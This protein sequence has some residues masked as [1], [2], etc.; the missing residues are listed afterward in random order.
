[1]A[2][3]A[4]ARLPGLGVGNG[5]RNG[6]GPRFGDVPVA[7]VIPGPAGERARPLDNGCPKGAK[8]YLGR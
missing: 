2:L 7:N 6:V 5:G 4:R 3:L 1:M 8:W